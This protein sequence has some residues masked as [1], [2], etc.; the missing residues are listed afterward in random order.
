MEGSG[1]YA[2]F[3]RSKL[4]SISSEEI[5]KGAQARDVR[6]WVGVETMVA[7]SSYTFEIAKTSRSP[8]EHSKS[9]MHV[10]GGARRP[11][12]HPKP[13]EQTLRS[14]VLLR[15]GRRHG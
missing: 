5:R 10:Q 11:L 6:S 12:S 7:S 3:G 9:M 14:T 8:V 4:E 1:I 15:P 2:C 13:F